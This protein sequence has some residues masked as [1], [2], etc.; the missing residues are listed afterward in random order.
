MFTTTLIVVLVPWAHTHVRFIQLDTLNMCSLLY[1]SYVGDDDDDDL[2]FMNFSFGASLPRENYGRGRHDTII[3]KHT[4]TE[5]KVRP[6][7][8]CTPDL[9]GTFTI[10]RSPLESLQNLRPLSLRP[11]PCSAHVHRQ[12]RLL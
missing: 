4:P 10:T 12:A 5:C 3:S 6:L 2:S 9:S 1:V 11:S 8:I 7:P